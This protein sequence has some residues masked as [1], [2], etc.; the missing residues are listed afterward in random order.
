MAVFLS[1][2]DFNI[3]SGRKLQL[4]QRVYGFRRRGI[5]IHQSFVCRKLKLLSCFLVNV[6]RTQYGEDSFVGRQRNRTVYHSTGRLY[7]LYDFLSR[8]VYQVVIV[9]F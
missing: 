3:Y 5:D 2:F 7:R 4:H 6:R 1:H 9:R 8:L